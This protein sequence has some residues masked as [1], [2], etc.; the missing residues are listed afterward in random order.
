MLRSFLTHLF[1][2]PPRMAGCTPQTES[3]RLA[4]WERRLG[5]ERAQRRLRDARVAQLIDERAIVRVKVTPKLPDEQNV[6]P[7]RRRKVA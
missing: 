7:I 2:P 5:E 1:C 3:E 4:L 6:V